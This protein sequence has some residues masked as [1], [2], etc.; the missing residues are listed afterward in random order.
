VAKTSFLIV[1]SGN[2]EHCGG[3]YLASA[4][5]VG[6]VKRG[7]HRTTDPAGNDLPEIVVDSTRKCPSRGRRQGNWRDFDRLAPS[8]LFASHKRSRSKQ[9]DLREFAEVVRRVASP[10]TRSPDSFHISVLDV[11][12]TGLIDIIAASRNRPVTPGLM[13]KPGD[14]LVSCINPRI[15]RVA[16]VPDIPGNWTCSSEFLVLRSRRG[17]F[18]CALAVALHDASVL[19]AVRAMAGG[20]SSSRQRVPKDL[21]LSIPIPIPSEQ[22]VALEEHLRTRAEFYRVRLLEARAYD[23]LHDGSGEF[24][25]Y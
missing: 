1:R 7:N 14:V 20:T 12:E 23:R 10:N 8:R 13:C 11:D 5:H 25:L 6:F 18:P 15:W 16:L 21:L 3:I 2:A 9:N 19:R 22:T 17:V 4:E 24:D